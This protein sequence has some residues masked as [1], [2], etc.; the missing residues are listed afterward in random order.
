MGNYLRYGSAF[1]IGPGRPGNPFE[2]ER[3][4]KPPECPECKG[5][6]RP[7]GCPNCRKFPTISRHRP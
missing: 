1:H 2:D 7:G 4:K 3:D 5:R 6:G